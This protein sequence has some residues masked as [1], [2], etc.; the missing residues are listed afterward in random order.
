MNRP[1]ELAR[2]ALPLLLFL[3]LPARADEIALVTLHLADEIVVK[4]EVNVVR[5]TA[6]AVHR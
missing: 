6:P 3:A 1:N 4:R 5:A 2:L